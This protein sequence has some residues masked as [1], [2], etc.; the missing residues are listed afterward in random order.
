MDELET[1]TFNIKYSGILKSVEIAP[2]LEAS[3]GKRKV[4]DPISR[5]EIEN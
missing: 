3:G 1:R 2:I 5:Y 4:Y